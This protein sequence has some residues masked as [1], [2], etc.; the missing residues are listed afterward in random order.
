MNIDEPGDSKIIENER[1]IWIVSNNTDLTEGRGSQYPQYVCEKKS[2]ALRL[3]KGAGIQGGDAY[4]EPGKGFKINS[5]WY[6]PRAIT[7]PNQEDLKVEKEIEEVNRKKAERDL[8]LDKAKSL[9][10]SEADIAILKG[11]NETTNPNRP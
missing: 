7:P 10:L 5:R 9:G 4:V 8:I 1:D 2:T 11:Y 6:F 3:A